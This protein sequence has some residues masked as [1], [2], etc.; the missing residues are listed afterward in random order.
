[1]TWSCQCGEVFCSFKAAERHANDVHR[2]GRITVNVAT[3][4]R[5]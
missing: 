5:P 4:R 1:M 2:G 3:R